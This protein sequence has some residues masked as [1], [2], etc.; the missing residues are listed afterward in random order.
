VEVADLDKQ[1]IDP[2]YVKEYKGQECITME[3]LMEYARCRGIIKSRIWIER[4]EPNIFIVRASVETQ[5]NALCQDFGY[6]EG[7]DFDSISKARIE[8]KARVLSEFTGIRMPCF[9]VVSYGISTNENPAVSETLKTISVSSELPVPPAISV[10]PGSPSINSLGSDTLL[11]QDLD[12]FVF[13]GTPDPVKPEIPDSAV[14]K[15]DMKLKDKTEFKLFRKLLN[16][17]GP[18][19]IDPFLKQ[20]SMGHLSTIKDLSPENIKGFNLFLR[21]MANEKL[22]KEAV[23]AQVAEALQAAGVKK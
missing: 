22:G 18:G 5:D 6:S 21:N 9:E 19:T 10:T 16:L 15:V 8:A 13:P 4:F 2:K 7:D 12:E 11:A 3:G 1:T 17:E 23:T 20:W 14:P